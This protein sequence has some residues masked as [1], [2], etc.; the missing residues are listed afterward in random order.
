MPEH[1]TTCTVGNDPCARLVR[2]ANRLEDVV[3]RDFIDLPP[4][5][6]DERVGL[7]RN[8]IA[9][10]RRQRE[11]AE[12]S[13]RPARTGD[14]E[15]IPGD[16]EDF[17]PR[18]AEYLDRDPELERPEPVIDEGHDAVRLCGAVS[19]GFLLVSGL[20]LA[21]IHQLLAL[22]PIQAPASTP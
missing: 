14:L 4:G 5:R 9:M 6:D 13:H 2:A 16:A 19:H 21:K 18:P 10:I 12:A 7:S 22:L 15:V 8:V 11:S 17:R 3:R 20:T 1:E